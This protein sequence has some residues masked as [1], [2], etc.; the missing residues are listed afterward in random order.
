MRSRYE[1]LKKTLLGEESEEEE[2]SDDAVSDALPWQHGLGNIQL[3]EEDTTYLLDSHDSIFP[4]DNPKNTSFAINFFTSI[5]SDTSE[6]DEG[7]S[8]RDERRK[9]R[10]R[11][12]KLQGRRRQEA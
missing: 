2:G 11:K 12:K 4:K 1:E 5:E 6:S 9:K 7:E 10:R 3:T 8:D